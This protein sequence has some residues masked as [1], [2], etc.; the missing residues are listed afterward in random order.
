MPYMM[1]EDVGIDFPIY[2]ASARLLRKTLFRSA[3]GGFIGT[4][5]GTGRVVVRA[6]NGITLDIQSGDRVALLGH[7]G[8][9][10]TT[11]LRCMSGIYRPT[12]GR[13]SMRGRRV[14]LFDIGLGFDEEASGYEN[15]LLRGLLMG[16]TRSE[17]ENRIEDIAAFSGLGDFL[18][19]PVRTYS[20]GM[21]LRLLFSLATSVNADILLMDEWIAT[22][23]QEFVAK[24]NR[25]LRG[26]VDRS[27]ILVLAS[28]DLGLLESVCTRA[29]LLESGRI[30]FE[31]PVKEAIERYTLP[32][33]G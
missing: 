22:G 12:S 14:P 13:L 31:G 9:G 17:I 24:A 32:R 7:N 10:K 29:V 1:L 30:A 26:L 2:Q 15:I 3:V 25:R 33:R 5:E 4:S 28:H 23:D 21:G 8:A 11:L 16:L 20:S 27:H 19:L 18:D 6:L